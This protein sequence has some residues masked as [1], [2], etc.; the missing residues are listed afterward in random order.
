MNVLILGDGEEEA[1]WAR[2]LLGRPDHGLDAAYPGFPDAS[3]AGIPAPRDFED[4][5][6]RPG[7]EA[8]IVG[9]PPESRGEWLRRVA[10]EGYAIIAL[11]PPGPDSEAYHQVAL[12]REET[13]AVILPG[14]PLRLH[15]GVQA[16][17]RALS[18]GALGAFRGLRMEAIG[19][20]P[21][22]SLVRVAFARAVDVLR[23][24]LGEIEALTATG[25]PPGADPDLEL[26]VQLRGAGPLRGEARI[27]PDA[28]ASTRLT[29]LGERGSLSL[30]VEAHR[31]TLTRPGAEEPIELPP[32]EPHE[33]LMAVLASSMG[34]R[35]AG[36]SPSPSLLDG[37]RAMEL[38]EAV[39][40][41]LRRGRTVELYYESISEESTFKSVMTSTG[42]LV[43]LA[44]LFVLPLAMVGAA[45]GLKWALYVPYLIPPALILFVIL[46]T[47]RP[48]FRRPR[49]IA[50]PADRSDGP[51]DR[52]FAEN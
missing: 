45:I 49:A 17:R 18:E 38:S 46:Q 6:A 2:W 24:I 51:K 48:A 47:L 37:T 10:A 31:L 16:L 35:D 42:C 41:S 25:D 23:A 36:E 40:R 13:G 43:F 29:L 11:H 28:A 15:P 30:D 4:A 34:R 32:W 19:P 39:N 9:G 22:A 52:A 26:V 50:A 8:I 14:L 21:A 33:A 44:S 5:L 27:R 20:P 7:V 3:M 1:A 12:S